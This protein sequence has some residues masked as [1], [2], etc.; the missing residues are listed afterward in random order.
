MALPSILKLVKE[1]QKGRTVSN[2]SNSSR[3]SKELQKS[4]QVRER[5]EGS[6]WMRGMDW[7]GT[8]GRAAQP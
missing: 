1:E 3:N 6:A 2:D 7:A 4:R 5:H 8:E